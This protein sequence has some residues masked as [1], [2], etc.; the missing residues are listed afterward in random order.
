M[1]NGIG[2]IVAGFVITL[3]SG[4]TQGL[5]GFG[6]SLVFVSFMVIFLPPKIVVPVVTIHAALI[7][8]MIIYGARRW[9]ELRRVWPLML[10]GV[11]GMPLG[12]YLL[13]SLSAQTLKPVIGVIIILFAVAFL[14][15]FEH[16]LRK[17]TAASIFVGF[18]SGMLNAGTGM[19]GPPV[20]LFFTNQGVSKD[21]FR[22]NLAAYFMFVNLSTLLFFLYKGLVTADVARYS[23]M[24]LPGLVIGAVGGIRLSAAVDENIFKKIA[25]LIVIMA[26]IMSVA[27]RAYD[28]MKSLL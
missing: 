6:Y 15:G 25:L 19:S 26:G 20:I 13:I 17:E 7:N 18:L 12:T 23:A 14:S 3:V 24:L 1:M 11:C 5:T 16:K 21:V 8:V 27:P 22:A 28:L 10:A 9:I 4:I 2:I